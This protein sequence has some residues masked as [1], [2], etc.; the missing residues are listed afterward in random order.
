MSLDVYISLTTIPSRIKR[1]LRENLEDLLL[2]T[3]PV[4]GIIITIPRS[5]MRGQA[6]DT[7]LPEWLQEEP[8]ASRV[9]IL[10]PEQ[11]F[12][13]ILKYIGGKDIV[14]PGA[15][16]FACDDDQRYVH[17]GIADWIAEFDTNLQQTDILNAAWSMEPASRFG[18]ELISGYTGVLF[19]RAFM[20][21]ILASFDPSLPLHA[22]RIDDDLVSLYAR[23]NGF[24]KQVAPMIMDFAHFVATGGEGTDS[25]TFSFNRLRDRHRTHSR[26]NPNYVQ[27]LQSLV[28]I[29]GT[30]TGVIVVAT[31]ASM[32]WGCGARK[33]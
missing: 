23:D 33:T 9:T 32:A 3:Y 14:P 25:L 24:R 30:L 16:V 21:V 6:V 20:D 31:V 1:V 11:D 10:Q 8:F 19:S 13:P 15:W 7:T 29:A 17:T 18:F 5:N 27:K 26:M 28:V 4:K 12:G 2:Q 22:L